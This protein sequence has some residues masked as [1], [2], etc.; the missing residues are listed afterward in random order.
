MGFYLG[1][2]RIFRFG[3]EAAVIYAYCFLGGLTLIV[4]R[5]LQ[6]MLQIWPIGGA[7]IIFVEKFVDEEVAKSVAVLYW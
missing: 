7:L 4:M 1:T 6:V 2:G 5:G 3:G